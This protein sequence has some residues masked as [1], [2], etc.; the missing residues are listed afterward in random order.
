METGKSDWNLSARLTIGEIYSRKQLMAILNTN[1]ATINNG[2]FEAPGFRSVLLFVTEKKQADRRQYIDEL[3]G[4]VL[5]MEGQGLRKT[6]TDPWI[7]GHV[8]DGRELLLFHRAAKN[9]YPAYGFK[10]QGPFCFE[11]VKEDATPEVPS[12]F[13][14]RRQ[15]SLAI[16]Q[17]E[18]EA[19]HAFDPANDVDARTRVNT[20]IVRRRGQK[21][22]REQLLDAYGAR[23]AVSGSAVEEILEAAHIAPYKGDHTNHVTNGLLLRADLHTLFDLNRISVQ[24]PELTLWVSKA[25]NGSEYEDLRGRQLYKPTDGRHPN[26]SALLAHLALSIDREGD[27]DR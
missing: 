2:I 8:S 22:F 3:N 14:L 16:A 1:N 21:K 5:T 12:Q 26:E 18:L 17:S 25:L 13:V 15:D 7:K 9:T 19:A 4:D 11:S 10:Y 20:S 23:C 6:V 27:G 24:A